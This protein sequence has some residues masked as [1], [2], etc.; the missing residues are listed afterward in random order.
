MFQP[1]SSGRLKKVSRVVFWNRSLSLTDLGYFGIRCLLV[2]F[3]KILSAIC[4]VFLL[5]LPSKRLAL[6]TKILSN[7]TSHIPTCTT[8]R[9]ITKPV[10]RS[11]LRTCL[12]ALK[13]RELL[14]LPFSG[15][16]CPSQTTRKRKQH[17]LKIKKLGTPSLRKKTTFSE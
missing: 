6:S 17:F 2:C 14:F 8:W 3:F 9:E 16:V 10:P 5:S 4:V 7:V 12:F 15:S 1:L 11:F 13:T